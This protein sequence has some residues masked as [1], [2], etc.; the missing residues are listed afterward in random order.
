MGGDLTKEQREEMREEWTSRKELT[1]HASMDGP[2][3]PVARPRVLSL[4]DALDSADRQI[5]IE[6]RSAL[7]WSK[8]CGALSGQ[9]QDAFAALQEMTAERAGLYRRI[10]ELTRLTEHSPST[11]PETTAATPDATSTRE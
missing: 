8:Q 6:A 4:L 7:Y 5:A 9:L 3:I 10:D 11:S 2:V 1:D